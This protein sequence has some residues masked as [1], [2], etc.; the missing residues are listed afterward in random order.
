MTVSPI[1]LGQKTDDLHRAAVLSSH[2]VDCGTEDGRP[3]RE[4]PDGSRTGN[5]RAENPLEGVETVHDLQPDAQGRARELH[6]AIAVRSLTK[7]FWV[8]KARFA[9]QV[10]C[11]AGQR[12]DVGSGVEVMVGEDLQVEDS[13]AERQ[14]GSPESLRVADAAEG[15]DLVPGEVVEGVDLT[16]AVDQVEGCVARFDEGH[17]WCRDARPSGGSLPAAAGS[18]QVGPREDDRGGAAERG[19]RL[20]EEPTGKKPPQTEGVEGVEHD[21]VKIASQPAMLEPVVEDDQLGLEFDGR[22]RPRA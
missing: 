22:R 5:Q 13:L 17:T 11:P 14:H 7:S 8:V 20:S 3:A 19:D 16:V 21:Q 15:G 1:R 12:A 2:S 6:Q 4:C 10:A 18:R 9:P